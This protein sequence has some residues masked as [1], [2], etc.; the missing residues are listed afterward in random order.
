MV[1]VFHSKE[2]SKKYIGTI[3]RYM[4]L[5]VF[6]DCEKLTE[7]REK[8]E[9]YAQHLLFFKKK[10]RFFIVIHKKVTIETLHFHQIL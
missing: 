1:R 7:T 4:C 10:I 9:V 5:I 2:R 6:N 3:V 8:M